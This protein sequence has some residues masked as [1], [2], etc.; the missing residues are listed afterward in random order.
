M[1]QRFFCADQSLS[2]GEKLFGT[3][4][5][6][7]TWFLLEYTGRWES[8]AFESS[9]LPAPVKERLNH[10]LAAVP[11]SRL[12]LIRQRPRTTPK[13]IAFYVGV[14]REIQPVL[15]A[16]SLED[17]TDLLAL[18][19]PAIVAGE[20]AYQPFLHFDP[21]FLVCTNGRRDQCCSVYGIPAYNR[22]REAEGAAVWQTTHVGGHRF[23]ANLIT[24]PH[25]IYNGRVHPENIRAVTEAYRNNQLFPDTYRGRACYS[26]IV[27]AAEFYLRKETGITDLGAFRWLDTQPEDTDRWL[28]RFAS[29]VEQMIH[30]LTVNKVDSE[31]LIYESCANEEPVSVP[32]YDLL[33]YSRA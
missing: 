4:S 25:A 13:G 8:K 7:T 2:V 3:V 6:V 29:T 19:L 31:P 15:Y 32:Q 1:S 33:N 23:A 30:S 12:Q 20:T 16:F 9:D 5:T 11:Q 18:D 14:A 22:L 24:F 28:V 21:L 26:K 10:H 27:Q 17:Y